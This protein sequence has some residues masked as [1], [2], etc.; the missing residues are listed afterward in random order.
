MRDLRFWMA[1]EAPSAI[2]RQALL[3]L[4]KASPSIYESVHDLMKHVH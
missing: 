2:G 4:Q 3:E 1:L